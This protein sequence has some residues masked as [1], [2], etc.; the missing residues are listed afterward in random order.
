MELEID[1]NK[2]DSNVSL[3]KY[4]L[5][6]SFDIIKV[7]N[8]LF[9]EDNEYFISRIEMICK[10]EYNIS[11]KAMIFQTKDIKGSRTKTAFKERI[12]QILYHKYAL[13]GLMICEDYIYRK[14]PLFDLYVKEEGLEISLKKL[15][16]FES[17]HKKD[18]YKYLPINSSKY[19]KYWKNN[20]N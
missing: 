19:K 18:I 14:T 13:F 3:D 6:S 12:R 16:E 20:A 17:R 10:R 15:R 4:G 1:E 9:L 5:P 7:L 11:N 8:H 2:L